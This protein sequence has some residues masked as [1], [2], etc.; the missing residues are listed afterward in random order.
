MKIKFYLA[1]LAV[2]FVMKNSYGQLPG[3]NFTP[4]NTTI[5]SGDTLVFTST[6][7]N[8]SGTTNYAWDFDYTIIG[9][10]TIITP[11][12][13]GNQFNGLGPVSVSFSNSGTAPLLFTVYLLVANG[14]PPTIGLDA[15]T[16]SVLITVLPAPPIPTV[17]QD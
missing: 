4:G 2:F 8:V 13:I 3:A 1:V 6:S 9:G 11:G 14:F 7:S 15:D 5:C 17:V 10:A 16:I 12:G